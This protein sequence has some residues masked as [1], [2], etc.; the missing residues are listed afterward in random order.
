[1]V[2]ARYE[3]AVREVY[4]RLV[5][6]NKLKMVATVA[7]M[8]RLLVALWVMILREQPFDPAKFGPKAVLATE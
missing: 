6:R 1:M 4:E 7:I 3:P 5:G 2:A 8:R